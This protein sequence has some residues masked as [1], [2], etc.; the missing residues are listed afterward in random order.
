MSATKSG[1]E[2]FDRGLIWKVPYF[3]NVY[4]C[5]RVS[6]IKASIRVVFQISASENRALRANELLLLVHPTVPGSTQHIL[7]DLDEVIKLNKTAPEHNTTSVTLTCFRMDGP[8]EDNCE[9]FASTARS[10]E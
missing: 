8:V 2:L 7:R 6:L 1:K 3:F 10:S 9:R 5:I 4:S